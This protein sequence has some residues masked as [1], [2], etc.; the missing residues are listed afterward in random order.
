MRSPAHKPMR[1]RLLVEVRPPRGLRSPFSFLSGL[2]CSVFPGRVAMRFPG[3]V[4]FCFRKTIKSSKFTFLFFPSCGGR[5]FPT[6]TW[7]WTWA[8][9][10]CGF[11]VELRCGL[12]GEREGR[13][14]RGLG[15]A[16]S[17]ETAGTVRSPRGTGSAL[18]SVIKQNGTKTGPCF[19]QRQPS[20]TGPTPCNA[21]SETRSNT[22]S[23]TSNNAASGLCLDLDMGI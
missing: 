23:E 12:R 9:S 6:C 3:R 7:T 11:G 10:R 20:G 22:A 13:S 18:F 17:E 14:P 16:V 15:C 2:S 1:L 21:A 5:R 4:A 19:T 8:L